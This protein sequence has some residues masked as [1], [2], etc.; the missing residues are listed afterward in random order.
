MQ[1]FDFTNV[2]TF[3]QGTFDQFRLR[4]L[5]NQ[6]TLGKF[7]GSTPN[8][9]LCGYSLGAGTAVTAT[10]SGGI[11][12]VTHAAHGYV[13]GDSIVLT[14]TS[15]AGT[16]A[17][18]Y[19]VS[20]I[21]TNTYQFYTSATGSVT[22]PVEM[23]FFR[24][25]NSLNTQLISNITRTGI[26]QYTIYFKN[27]QSTIFYPIY[28]IGANASSDFYATR[29]IGSPP[30]STGSFSVAMANPGIAFEEMSSYMLVQLTNIS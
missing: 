12:T 19:V 21:T 22:S 17:G 6:L 23:F 28:V 7:L 1:W 18:L 26:G 2:D 10:I 29:L 9:V 8:V 11:C 4:K 16:F 30:V 15:G 3:L 27:T 5:I 25:V 13:V 20:A 24:G 14:G